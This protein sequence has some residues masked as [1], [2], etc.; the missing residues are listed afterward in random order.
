M[1][2]AVLMLSVFHRLWNGN[3]ICAVLCLVT[4]SCPTPCD[5]MD[6]NFSVHGDSP[7]KN[8]GVCC[9]VLLQGIFPTQELNLGLPPC[10]W[11]LSQL[12]YQ[13]SPG[14]VSTAT[15]LI[16]NRGVGGKGVPLLLRF[17]QWGKQTHRAGDLPGMLGYHYLL[18][19]LAVRLALLFV[20]SASFS[21]C[22]PRSHPVPTAKLLRRFQLN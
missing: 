16:E 1:Q 7:G 14:T 19:P 6:C 11:I 12:S 18:G 13:G 21:D 5:P 20:T 9:H 3:S 4:Q 10:R 2:R 17:F 15:R 22:L 8:A